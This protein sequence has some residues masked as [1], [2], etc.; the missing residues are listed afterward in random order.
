MHPKNR[1]PTALTLAILLLSQCV[2]S[3]SFK[4][5]PSK[6]E[7]RKIIESDVEES[8][9]KERIFFQGT[10]LTDILNNINTNNITLSPLQ[11]TVFAIISV[12]IPA[13]LVGVLILA[14]I[15]LVGRETQFSFIDEMADGLFGG[16]STDTA[17]FV[18]KY[19][20]K[21]MDLVKLYGYTINMD[22]IKEYLE[23]YYDS[24]QEEIDG[25]YGNLDR[26]LNALGF[27][28]SDCRRKIICEVYRDR[29]VKMAGRKLKVYELIRSGFES[30]QSAPQNKRFQ[31]LYKDLITAAKSGLNGD[32]R[33]FNCLIGL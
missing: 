18:G 32:C 21:L 26:E 3:M 15:A 2:V 12:L 20:H 24:A 9:R 29:K 25:F 14:G 27:V 28:A 16:R 7:A 5:K 6:V 1:I 10:S 22:Q 11:F 23:N 30:N 8:S 33:Q 31:N 13:T 4:C 17:S 19:S